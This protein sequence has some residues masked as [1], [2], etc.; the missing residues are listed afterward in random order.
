MGLD[1]AIAIF[2]RF[3]ELNM[4]NLMS[5]QSEIV[6]LRKCLRQTC[7]LDDESTSR[8]ESRYSF[9]F[10]LSKDQNSEQYKLL[11]ALRPKLREYSE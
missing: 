10:K 5:L 1:Q 7:Q 4:L 2:P 9:S 11:M 6:E 3:D 8:D